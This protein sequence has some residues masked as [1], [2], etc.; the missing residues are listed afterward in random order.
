[1]TIAETTIDNTPSHH[2]HYPNFM[3]ER[4]RLVTKDKSTLGSNN[5]PLTIYHYR[6][7]RVIIYI[8]QNSVTPVTYARPPFRENLH[9]GGGANTLSMS[10]AQP[11]QV[12]LF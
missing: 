5:Q 1:M 3:R 9:T 6:G 11:I 12:R 10:N 2:A 7:Y 4:F 8:L